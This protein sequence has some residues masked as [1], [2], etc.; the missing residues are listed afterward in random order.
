MN[1][2]Q[3]S[4]SDSDVGTGTGLL[5]PQTAALPTDAYGRQTRVAEPQPST[6]DASLSNLAA[7][8][9]SFPD[10]RLARV[11]ALKA[12]IA[13]GT[14]HVTSEQLAAALFDHMRAWSERTPPA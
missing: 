5:E 12:Q 11:R 7:V 8:A 3:P 14:Y 10:L 6:T 9:L 2:E 4:R 1:Q 13:A